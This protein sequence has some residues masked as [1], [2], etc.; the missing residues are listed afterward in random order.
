MLLLQDENKNTDDLDDDSERAFVLEA[1]VAV[2]LQFRGETRREC[3]CVI[4]WSTS[5]RP[6]EPEMLAPL[7]LMPE[8]VN[9]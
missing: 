3:V 1:D 8:F 5:G 7:S 9:G 2:K 4:I 6:V